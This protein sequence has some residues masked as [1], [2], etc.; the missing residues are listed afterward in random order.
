MNLKQ[1]HSNFCIK[2]FIKKCGSRSKSIVMIQI[3]LRF[4]NMTWQQCTKVWTQLVN[5]RSRRWKNPFMILMCYRN[6]TLELMRG[7]S[8]WPWL[9]LSGKPNCFGVSIGSGN[10]SKTKMEIF[11]CNN[12]KAKARPQ[13]KQPRGVLA[14]VL[15]HFSVKT[16]SLHVVSRVWSKFKDVTMTKKAAFCFHTAALLNSCSLEFKVECSHTY[17]VLATRDLIYLTI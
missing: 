3:D 8:R 15:M 11:N 5:V 17:L 13:L 10:F 12:L 14:S 9:T 16:I 6:G 1:Y 7:T 4:K 2:C